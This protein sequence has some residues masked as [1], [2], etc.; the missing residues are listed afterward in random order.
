LLDLRSSPTVLSVP[1]LIALS[2]PSIPIKKTLNNPKHIIYKNYYAP[3]IN[4]M[5]IFKHKSP[6]GGD[7][8]NRT[9][10]QNTFYFTS[11]SNSLLNPTLSAIFT[12]YV[13]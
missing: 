7:G 4:P 12:L 9:L 13:K 10:V 5:P 6:Y 11:Y 3:D 8:G 2:K 1:L